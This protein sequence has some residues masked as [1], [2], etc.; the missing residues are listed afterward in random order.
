MPRPKKERIVHRPPIFSEY[1][2]V[3]T[4][5]RMLDKVLLTLDEY[6]A[7]RLADFEGLS[8]EEAAEEMEVSRST[9]TRLVEK[10]RQKTSDFLINGKVLAIEGGNIHFRRNTIKCLN[11]GY[12]FNINIDAE[13]AQCPQCGSENLVNLAGGFGHGRCCVNR[14]KKGG[15]NAGRR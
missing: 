7:L 11:C 5:K 8:H 3:G 12:M 1:K 9:F 6:E 13:F 15:K 2:P 4:G 10:A 14:N